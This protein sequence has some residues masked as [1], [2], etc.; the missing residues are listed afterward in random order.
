MSPTWPRQLGSLEC[1]AAALCSAQHGA[2]RRFSRGETRR[3]F[4]A[5]DLAARMAGIRVPPR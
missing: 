4:T 1:N 2:G 3:R 5:E